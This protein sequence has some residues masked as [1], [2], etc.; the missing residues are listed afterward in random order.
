MEDCLWT[1]VGRNPIGTEEE[2]EESSIPLWKQQQRDVMT[3]PQ[4]PFPVP[5]PWEVN[6]EKNG[7]EACG[8]KDVLRL[9]FISNYCILI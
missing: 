9:G 7:E 2:H 5:A 8:G 4:P 3:W 1:P 6:P